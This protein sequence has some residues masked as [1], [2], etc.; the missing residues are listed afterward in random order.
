MEKPFV[1]ACI[2]QAFRGLGDSLVIPVAAGG[3]VFFA[4]MYAFYDLIQNLQLLLPAEHGL[5]WRI[6]PKLLS[7]AV[8]GLFDRVKQGV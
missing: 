1:Y 4:T 5:V 2:V 8:A 3:C 7:H 6:V